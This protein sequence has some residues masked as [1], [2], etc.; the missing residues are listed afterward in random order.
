MTAGI[1]SA[2]WSAPGGLPEQEE[3]F[4]FTSE[5]QGAAFQ[6]VHAVCQPNVP[7]LGLKTIVW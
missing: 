3:A 5:E 2:F 7:Q 6:A 4:A 1:W